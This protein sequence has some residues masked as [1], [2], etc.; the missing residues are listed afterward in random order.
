MIMCTKIDIPKQ[1]MIF[2]QLISF[3]MWLKKDRVFYIP[4]KGTNA[5]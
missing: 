3:S 2:F 1:F 5:L 4:W